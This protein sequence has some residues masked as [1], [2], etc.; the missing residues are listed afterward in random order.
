M[1]QIQVLKIGGMTCLHCTAKMT[2]ILK[3]IPGVQNAKVNLL[4]EEAEVMLN[5]PVTPE[6][7][8]K[9]IGEA[10]YKFNGIK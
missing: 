9:V 4:N 2:G 10:G 7:F 6:T 8:A 1:A 5:A 3:T